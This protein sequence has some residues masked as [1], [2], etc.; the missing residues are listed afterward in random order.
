MALT[1]TRLGHGPVIHPAL[2][3][4]LGENINGPS[5]VAVPK[6]VPRPLGKFYLYFA[7]HE[8]THIR[9]AYADTLTGPWTI[10]APGVLDVTQSLFVTSDPPQPPRSQWPDW[11]PAHS[12]R[13]LYAHVASPD[14]HLDHSAGRFR[15]YFHGLLDNSEQ[16][17]RVAYSNDGLSFTPETALLGPPYFRVFSHNG[18]I[19]GISWAGKLHR[20]RSWNGPFEDGPD[21]LSGHPMAGANQFLRHCAVL[22]RNDRLDLFFSRI[23]DCP[24]HILHCAIRLSEDWNEWQ[25]ETPRALLMPKEDWEGGDL[26]VKRS[27][28]GAANGREHALRDPCIF[29]H[30]GDYFLFYCGGGE[31]CIGLARLSG[32]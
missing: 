24:E 32:L 9:M 29:S 12:D 3:P 27:E 25:V 19:Y 2:H 1:A 23:G 15:M 8:G 4:G 13:Y 20:S 7:H 26:P 31:G 21:L 17:T 6:W 22:C 16:Q 30:A 28:A 5:V 10:Y 11:V 14:I 18:W